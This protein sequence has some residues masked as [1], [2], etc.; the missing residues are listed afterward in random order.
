VRILELTDPAQLA[1]FAALQTLQ[2]REG[3]TA[4]RSLGATRVSS[5]KRVVSLVG[6][7]TRHVKYSHLDQTGARHDYLHLTLTDE[8]QRARDGARAG[9]AA[10]AHRVRQALDPHRAFP[11]P[12]Q[13]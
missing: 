10:R 8:R 4:T 12:D 6:A 2:T 3:K 5:G 1:G 11:L 13:R 9:G 7:R